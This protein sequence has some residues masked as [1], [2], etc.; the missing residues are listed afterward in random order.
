MN[1]GKLTIMQF[2]QKKFGLILIV[3]SLLLLIVLGFVK[4]KS[5]QEEEFLCS[6]VHTTPTA[7]PNQCPVH[8]GGGNT[9][10]ITA[11]FGVAF[12][13]L[14]A[15]IYFFLS[16][17]KEKKDNGKERKNEKRGKGAKQDAMQF[18][19][20]D[21]SK[22]DGEELKIYGLLKKGEGSVYQSDLVRETGISKVRITRILDR[23]ETKRILERKRRGMANLVVLK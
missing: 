6:V 21:L 13:L 17:P 19:R 5:D 2:D 8:Q 3:L 16:A 11:A 10:P 23:M 9:W 22:L 14:G 4:A 12:L 7:N 20:V 15:G 18:S 1:S